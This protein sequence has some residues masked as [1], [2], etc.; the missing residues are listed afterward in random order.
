[1]FRQHVGPTIGSSRRLSFLGR[2]DY[3]VNTGIS[4]R[5]FVAHT[6]E[7]QEFSERSSFR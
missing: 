6:T 5:Y 7:A 1:M 4:T 2:G 3:G